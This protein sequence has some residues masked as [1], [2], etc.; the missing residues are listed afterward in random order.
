MFRILA[1]ALLLLV[2]KAQMVAADDSLNAIWRD[3]FVSTYTEPSRSEFNRAQKLFR[4]LF[5]GD[6]S[7]EVI[8]AWRELG[9]ELAQWES[10]QR[11]FYLLREREDRR[12]GRGFFVFAADEF[13]SDLILQMPHGKSDLYTGRIGAQLMTEHPI[14]AAAWNTAP[15]RY[16]ENGITINADMGKHKN[17]FFTAFTDGM[18]S[19]KKDTVTIQLHGFS[20]LNRK[21]MAAAGADV[22]VSPGVKKAN[23]RT[24]AYHACLRERLKKNILLFP[25][26]VNELGGTLNI[27]GEI[28]SKYRSHAFIHLELNK[29]LRTELRKKREIRAHLIDCLQ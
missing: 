1:V 5:K 11:D 26:D 21:T 6:T 19:E 3:S 27:S 16:D 15:R 9:Y 7:A 28:L 29:G 12:L 24:D 4:R 22:I 14:N 23:E 20:G 10:Q 2:I 25:K 18:A 13:D 8:A 17:S